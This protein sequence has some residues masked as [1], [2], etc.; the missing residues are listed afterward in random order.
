MLQK[1]CHDVS[2]RTTL[3]A[4]RKP[5]RARTFKMGEPG[6]LD[7]NKALGLAFRIEDEEI[8]RKVALRK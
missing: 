7:L 4:R 3:T 8:A 2:M 5:Y 1:R 6:G